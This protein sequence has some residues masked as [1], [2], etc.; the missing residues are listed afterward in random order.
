MTA[1]QDDILSAV[2]DDKKVTVFDYRSNKLITK[3]EGHDQ[4]NFAIA[5]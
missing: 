2:T 1:I 5:F 3:L 4:F